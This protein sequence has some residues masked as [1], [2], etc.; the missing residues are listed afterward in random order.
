MMGRIVLVDTT[1]NTE[2]AIDGLIQSDG[3]F[4]IPGE[5]TESV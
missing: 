1:M 3:S 4:L 2:T 5:E